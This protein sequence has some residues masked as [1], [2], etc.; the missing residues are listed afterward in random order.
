[1]FLSHYRTR[2]LTTKQIQMKKI[3][4]LAFIMLLTFI[5]ANAQQ[6]PHYTQYMYN[7]NIINPAY[8]GSKENLSF[9]LLYRKQWVEI[10]DAPTTLT[11]SGSSPVGKNVGI[12]LSV[13]SD[14][15]GPVEENNV[16]ADFS[17]TLNLGGEH[18][19][20]LGLKAGATFLNVGLF[21]EIYNNVPDA[22][23]PAF[24]ENIN[25]TNFNL[26]T[27]IFYYTNKYYIAFSIPNMLTSP[28]LDISRGG[29]DMEFGSESV[30]YF[31][32]GGYVFDLSQ[33]VKFKPFVMA[34]SAFN[35]PVSIDV[36]TNFLFN[37]RFEIG[38]T[39]RLE[40]SFGAMANFAIT[41]N[42][43]IGYAYDHIVSDLK[44]TT[45]SSHEI[46]LLFDL[47]FPKKVS[48]SPRFF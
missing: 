28:H 39:Y 36:S 25:R 31:L 47:N 1:M 11:F 46:I 44:V 6:D 35:T 22:N 43:R 23:D 9:G 16:Y 38:A 17:Y 12:G 14:K 26:G 3:Y 41:P 4:I 15:I 33:N 2:L 21:D 24:S 18:K 20:A 45:P 34:K 19:L 29:D 5:D 37:E 42:L 30:H 8:A 40:D 10:Q 32:T 13:I 7:M 27:G 48:Q